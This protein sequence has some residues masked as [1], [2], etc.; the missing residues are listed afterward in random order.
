[1][2]DNKPRRV[3]RNRILTDGELAALR[4]EIES[5]DSIEHVDD[6]V[7]ALIESEWPDLV[8]KLPPKQKP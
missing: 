5:Y 3:F 8:G 7:R 4:P 6:E 2:P 1:M